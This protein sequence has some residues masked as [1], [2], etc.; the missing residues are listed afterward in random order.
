MMLANR[1]GQVLDKHLAHRHD[2]SLSELLALR[3]GD[4][5]GMRIQDLAEAVGLDRSSTSRLATRLEGKQL[6][7]RVSCD[8]DRRGIYC[9]IT[10][11]G[12]SRA[13]EAE[14]TLREEL[15]AMFDA[16]A[17]DDRTASLV[18]R[19]LRPAGERGPAAETRTGI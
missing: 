10:D 7:A 8:Y 6:A 1:F 17:F 3:D 19:L 14:G 2:V 5:R 11:L 16:A 9:G 15:A 18:A 4:Q 12:R 13:D